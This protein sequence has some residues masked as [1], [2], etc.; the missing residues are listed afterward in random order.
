MSGYWKV[1][2]DA[3]KRV[4]VETEN[5]QQTS[6][7][8][9]QMTD[10]TNKTPRTDA[11]CKERQIS[12]Q[13]ADDAGALAYLARYLER[14]L[15]AKEKELSAKQARIDALMLE[16]CPDEMTP[17]QIEEWGKNQRPASPELKANIDAALAAQEG[18]KPEY[19]FW[20]IERFEHQQSKGYWDGG[21]SRSFTPDIEKAIQFCRREDCFWATR[22][23]HWVD[24]QFTQ[25]QMLNIHNAPNGRHAH[26]LHPAEEQKEK[27]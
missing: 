15:A 21:S 1:G 8:E 2:S 25:H 14:A 11:L 23:W 26:A 5:G 4:W 13:R 16:Y 6:S 7:P 20:V 9:S 17:E 18:Q 24:T 19:F 22:G 27:P 10:P 12:P 3:S